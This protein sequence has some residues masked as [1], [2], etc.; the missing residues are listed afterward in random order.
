MLPIK[1]IC[2]QKN[3]RKD[4]TSL[5]FIQYCFSSENRTTVNTEI[6]IPP[7]F[8][9]KKQL[10]VSDKLP[11]KYGNAAQ[12]NV[13]LKRLIRLAED[14]ID[15][16]VSKKI[17]KD[18]AFLKKVFTPTL[19]LS[20]LTRDEE[21]LTVIVEQVTSKIDLNLYRQ[22]DDYI[23]SKEAYV[24]PVTVGV[25]EQMKDHLLAFEK[26]RKK[27]IT[28]ESFD[29]TFYRAFVQFL[30]TSTYKRGGKK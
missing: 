25:Y 22:I 15:F 11:A 5:I 14:I 17:E 16:A 6:A 24:S 28:F 21:K 3:V 27:P 12:L 4:G 18:A 8:W 1:P 9:N 20:T 29:Y 2:E 10:C 26:Y 19:D 7:P 30:T 13:E 23:S